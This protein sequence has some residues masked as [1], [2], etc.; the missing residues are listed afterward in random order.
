MPWFLNVK[1]NPQPVIV[2]GHMPETITRLLREGWVEVPDPRTLPAPEAEASA[3]LAPAPVAV[4]RY[5]DAEPAATTAR[6]QEQEQEQVTTIRK[7]NTS[8]REW[9]GRKH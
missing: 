2:P 4:P 7:R 5:V 1:V 9:A 3:L 6:E 8:A